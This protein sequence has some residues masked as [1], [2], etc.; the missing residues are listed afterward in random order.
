MGEYVICKVI[1]NVHPPE[2]TRKNKVAGAM[3]IL[4]GKKFGALPVR[5]CCP[6]NCNAY[7]ILDHSY[8]HVRTYAQ[9]K[10]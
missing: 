10:N 1:L 2:N 7:Y 4:E 3:D 8:L 9:G 6:F 5:D